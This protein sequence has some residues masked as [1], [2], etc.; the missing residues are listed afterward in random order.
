MATFSILTSEPPYY[1][2][3]CEF[4]GLSFK[5]YVFSTKT[6]NELNTLF[7][8]YVNNYELEYLSSN[9][10]DENKN[11]LPIQSSNADWKTFKLAVMTNPVLNNAIVNAIPLVTTA[12]LAIP[13]ALMKA[14]EGKLD[15]LEK[16]WDD[17]RE[18]SEIDTETIANLIALAISC[19]LPAS[20]IEILD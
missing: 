3:L 17:I 12:A 18:V 13:A 4:S 2:I 10:F 5:Q 19:N 7:Q 14:E 20:F 16:C 8:D 1:L 15:D 11:N 6:G 9:F